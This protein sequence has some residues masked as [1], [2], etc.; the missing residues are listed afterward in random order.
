MSQGKNET[1]ELKQGSVWL[2][3]VI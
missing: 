1:K 3:S 2:L